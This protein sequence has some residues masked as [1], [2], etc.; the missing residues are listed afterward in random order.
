MGTY[1]SYAFTP[2]DDAVII[3]AA[4]QIYSVPLSTNKRGERVGSSTLPF[5]IRFIAHIEKHLA[6]TLRGGV[7]VAEIESQD[8]QRVRAMRGLRVDQTGQK[9]VFQAAGVTYLQTV[10]EKE[11]TTVPVLRDSAPYYSPSFVPGNE[12]L[13][14]HARWS[15]TNFTSFELANIRT[16]VAREFVGLPMGRYF[17]PILCECSSPRRQI[18]FIK[19]GNSYLT[20][21]IVATAN[22]GLYIGDITLPSGES[23]KSEHIKIHSLHYVKSEIDP[24][25]R[26][27]MRFLDG[28]KKLLVQQ[29]SH[30][31]IIDLEAGSNEIGEYP[32]RTVASGRMSSEIVVSL[33]TTKGS[34]TADGVAFV[35]SFHVHF[36]HGDYLKEGESVWTK[37][38]NAT[39]GLARLSLDG[40]HDVTW[41]RDGKKVFWF[42]GRHLDHYCFTLVNDPVSRPIPA[43]PGDLQPG[44]VF[45][46]YQG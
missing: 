22:P 36:A 16:G 41:S 5:P 20:G 8:T 3:W 44:R 25:D 23:T 12:D 9:V 37:V 24:G 34:Y 28:N 40:G 10:G 2:S 27:N 43:L 6:T 13:V 38:G 26:V 45:V 18:A 42:L 31:F 21:D 19:S 46:S 15:D 14:L 32:H 30:A 7:D 1:P 35:D 33:K 29:S 17:S 39:K 11:V 4:G